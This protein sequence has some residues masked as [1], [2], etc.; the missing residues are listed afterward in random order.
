MWGINKYS[1]HEK[2]ESKCST[3]LCTQT[4]SEAVLS[5]LTDDGS[6]RKE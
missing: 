4:V 2:W 3:N 5:I 6:Q 1:G